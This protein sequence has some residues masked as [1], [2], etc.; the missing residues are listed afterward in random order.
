MAATGNGQDG[1]VPRL[2]DVSLAVLALALLAF[3]LV[4]DRALVDQGA[5][6]REKSAAAAEETA[7]LTAASVRAALGEI[8]EAVLG[9]RPL[10]DVSTERVAIPPEPSAAPSAGLPYA[11]RP[12]SELTALLQSTATTANVTYPACIVSL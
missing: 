9:G 1:G 11:R 4:A 2:G 3:G 10:T 7:R 5:A 8:E 6:V 12:R